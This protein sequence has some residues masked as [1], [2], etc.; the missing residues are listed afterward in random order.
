MFEFLRQA[1]FVV[2]NLTARWRCGISPAGIPIFGGTF[3]RH[4]VAIVGTA[5]FSA[6]SVVREFIRVVRVCAHNV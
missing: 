3:W 4:L 6:L 2:C 1:L 5:F